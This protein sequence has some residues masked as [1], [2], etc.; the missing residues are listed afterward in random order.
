MA[1]KV[2]EKLPAEAANLVVQCLRKKH[3]TA[4]LI[5]KLKFT[6]ETDPYERV[7]ALNV[8]GPG[9]RISGCGYGRIAS[10]EGYTWQPDGFDGWMQRF[11]YDPRVGEPIPGWSHTPTPW[12]ENWGADLLE[13][14]EVD[15][16]MRQR[17]LEIW[18]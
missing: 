3:P 13:E 14:I 17:L 8:S 16:E 2:L 11:F 15:E 1:S 18:D 12:L 10:I 9:L 5:S 7:P 6:H 4:L